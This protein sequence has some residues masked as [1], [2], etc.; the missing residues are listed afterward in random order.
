MFRN[1]NPGRIALIFLTGVL[2]GSLITLPV[3][4]APQEAPA[5]LASA[6][7]GNIIYGCVGTAAGSTSLKM[8]GRSLP[9]DSL[10]RVVPGG[11]SC[12][13]GET[14]LNWYSTPPNLQQI[15]LL[16][17]YDANQTGTTFTVGTNPSGIA[18]DGAN[19]WVV[20]SGSNT[21][22]KLKAADGSLV[23]TYSVGRYPIGI[24]FD[25]VNIWV[26]NSVGHS[27]T[28]LKAADG[29]L[30]GTYSVSTDP[31]VIAFDGA[32][33]WVANYGSNSVTKLKASDGSLVGTYGVGS[34]PYGLAFDGANI[35]VAN[36]GSTTVTKL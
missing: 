2:V 17:W 22:T 36:S 14:A 24:A 6:A 1:W 3:Y 13:S 32:N 23:G 7:S 25:G 18:F 8:G 30:V 29:S 31:R 26:A 20:N 35:W 10:L 21:V 27:V 12:G 9:S 4:S 33:I 34:S 15:A 5:L 19:I 11:Q 16:R 28:K